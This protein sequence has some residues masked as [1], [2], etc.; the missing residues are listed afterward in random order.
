MLQM[1]VRNLEKCGK[2][3]ERD[4]KP[5]TDKSGKVYTSIF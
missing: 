3:V 5:V 4:Q 2:S 1:A